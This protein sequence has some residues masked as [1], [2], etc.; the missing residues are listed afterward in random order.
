[1][2]E[3]YV[4]IVVD[5][6]K[7]NGETLVRIWPSGQVD[8]DWR[9]GPRES[10]L[11]VSLLGGALRCEGADGQPLAGVALEL[12]AE[13]GLESADPDAAMEKWGGDPF[14][15]GSS[16]R[17]ALGMLLLFATVLAW[18]IAGPAGNGWIQW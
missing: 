15:R 11:P 5:N 4:L 17:P 7:G 9:N 14:Q 12:E 18:A 10:W 13:R 3:D 8:A 6:G 16:T 2:S 1:M